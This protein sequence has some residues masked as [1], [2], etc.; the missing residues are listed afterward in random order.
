MINGIVPPSLK[1]RG[2][3][4]FEIWTNRGV[5]KKLLRNMGLVER[6][7]VLLESGGFPNCYISFSSEKYVFITIGFFCL[8]NIHTC[9]NQQTYSFM[10]FSFHQKMIYYEI[11]FPLTWLVRGVISPLFLRFPLYR[12]R[13]CPHLSW[14]YW[15]SKS[16]TE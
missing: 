4:C 5:M 9:C 15:E 16:S 13:R 7:G 11:S 1:I 14:A 10:W 8:V 12:N 2:G 6:E 3:S